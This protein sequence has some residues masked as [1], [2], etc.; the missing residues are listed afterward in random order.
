[1]GEARRDALRVGF[2]HA[3][4]LELHG[5]KVSSDAAPAPTFSTAC[6]SVAGATP[7]GSDRLTR[8]PSASVLTG[9]DIEV[10]VATVGAKE[11]FAWGLART[12]N[13]LLVGRGGVC[14][15]SF[16]C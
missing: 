5:A 7:R 3:I 9:R 15:Q 8:R 13:S 14:V 1:M 12:R 4:K 16:R 11:E 10:K 6:L 2:D